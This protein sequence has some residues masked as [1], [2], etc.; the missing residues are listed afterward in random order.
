LD[1]KGTEPINECSEI[2]S[3]LVSALKQMTNCYKR[4]GFDE[5]RYREMLTYL[6]ADGELI[7]VASELVR[8]FDI[9]SQVFRPRC[10]PALGFIKPPATFPYFAR[11]ATR[12]PRPIVKKLMC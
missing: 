4:L 11:F 6:G 9:E 8:H 12:I 7:R 3:T 1:E 10:F 2:L 5:K